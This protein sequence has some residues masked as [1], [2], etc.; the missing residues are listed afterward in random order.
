MAEKNKGKKLKIPF[1]RDKEKKK[2][3]LKEL[4]IAYGNLEDP[5]KYKKRKKRITYISIMLKWQKKIR[6]K[7]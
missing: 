2:D 6:E 1:H 4:K 5:E 7:N 3:A